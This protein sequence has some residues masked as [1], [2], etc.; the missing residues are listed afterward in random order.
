MS[1]EIRSNTGNEIGSKTLDGGSEGR[2]IDPDKLAGPPETKTIAGKELSLK[3]D[4]EK[5][6]ADK[7]AGP[8]LTTY[9]ER[10]DR[11][12]NKDRFENPDKRGESMALPDVSTQEGKKVAEKLA[13]YGQK[14]IEYRNGE[15]NFG[16][17]SEC[18]TPIEGMSSIRAENFAKAD[19]RC[20]ES[21]NAEKRDGRDDWTA[22]EVR[23]WRKDNHFSWHERC[24]TKTVDLV[25]QEVHG[26]FTHSGGVAECK[27]RDA[28]LG[29]GGLDVQH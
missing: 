16:P 23:Q 15:P 17:V 24:D 10:L 11:C 8:Y 3:G 9:K 29:N 27:K 6:D 7:V 5:V 19:K 20:A 13:E 25:P 14:G 2:P 18:T 28:R 12:P 1:P 26:H 21:W 4:V 22:S